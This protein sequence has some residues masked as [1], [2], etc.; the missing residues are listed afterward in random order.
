MHN[1]MDCL[2]IFN[3]Q[4]FSTKNDCCVLKVKFN[5]ILSLL[6]ILGYPYDAWVTSKRC[7]QPWLLDDA[8]DDNDK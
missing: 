8:Y 5:Q 1:F 3:L 6:C 7:D 2:L 4:Q